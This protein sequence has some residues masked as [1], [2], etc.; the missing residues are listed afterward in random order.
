MASKY[1]KNGYYLVTAEYKM[2]FKYIPFV[3]E[4][5]QMY[6]NVLATYSTTANN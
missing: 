2:I 6:S 4:L 1:C 5:H 3:Q